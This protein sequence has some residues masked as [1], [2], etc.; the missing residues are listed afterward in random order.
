MDIR[1]YCWCHVMTNSVMREKVAT[2]EFPGLM[3]LVG[4]AISLSLSIFLCWVWILISITFKCFALSLDLCAL[5]YRSQTTT[6]SNPGLAVYQF[7]RSKKNSKRSYSARIR[8]WWP[9]AKC[10]RSFR[11]CDWHSFVVWTSGSCALCSW[12]T[13]DI[14]CYRVLYIFWG[15]IVSLVKHVLYVFWLAC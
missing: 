14:I 3:V 9:A 15:L 11:E 6:S 2:S 12:F 7:N 10:E 8:V 13:C 5:W 4:C 1:W